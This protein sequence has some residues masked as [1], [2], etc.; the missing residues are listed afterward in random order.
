LLNLIR[1]E[2]MKIYRRLRTWMLMLLLIA[3]T[4]TVLIII[5]NDAPALKD[6]NWK[7]EV[8]KQIDENKKFMADKNTPE[9]AKTEFANF[10]KLDEYR[11]TNNIPPSDRSVWGGVLNAAKLII[12]VTIFTVVIAADSVA[13]EFGGGT[14]KLL[15]IR[16]AS[17]AKILLSKYISVLIFSVLLLA[18]LFGSS[19]LLSGFMEGFKDIGISHVYMDNGHMIHEVGIFGHVVNTYGYKCVDL[20]MI[21]TL[22]FMLSTV[23]RSSS[24]A[25][26]LSLGLLFVGSGIVQVISRY[27]WAKYYLFTNTD[28]TQYLN[29]QPIMEGMTLKFS[30]LVI[31]IY[32]LIFNIMSFSIFKKRDVAA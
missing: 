11:I 31:V 18:V 15:L 9:D 7:A 24:L 8:Q 32:F 6:G 10:I 21:V 26:G 12:I 3:L 4:S 25:I 22:A 14:I 27:S 29:N 17:R 5:H 28:L 23:F 16:P 2:N 1:N 13:G 20:I 30:I 19:F